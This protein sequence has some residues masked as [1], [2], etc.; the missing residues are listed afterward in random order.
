MQNPLV[1]Q[2]WSVPTEEVEEKADRR[3]IRIADIFCFPEIIQKTALTN[4]IITF[5]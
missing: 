2:P 5:I 3:K 4:S 1:P